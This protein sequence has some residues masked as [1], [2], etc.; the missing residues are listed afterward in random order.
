MPRSA[1]TKPETHIAEGSLVKKRV[2]EWV[3]TYD[4]L[5][6][7]GIYD[8]SYGLWLEED[9]KHLFYAS[10]STLGDA[11]SLKYRGT[12]IAGAPPY[13]EKEFSDQ[14][15]AKAWCEEEVK[16]WVQKWGREIER[17]TEQYE[18]YVKRAP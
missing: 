12:I 6:A 1:L 13:P 17:N 14:D 16:K 4:D 9:D 10:I 15:K 5:I 11:Y 18:R 8:A 7:D 3:P 2:Y